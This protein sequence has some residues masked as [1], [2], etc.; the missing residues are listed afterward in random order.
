[1]EL[2]SGFAEVIKHALISD[3]ERWDSIIKNPL[4]GQ[5][6]DALINHSVNFK[7]RVTTEDPT[8]KGLR[9]ILN[10]GHT[11]GHAM[12]SFLLEAGRKVMHG[13]AVA[14][15]LIA[16]T[17]IG[18]QRHMINDESFAQLYQYVLSIFGKIVFHENEVEHIALL[19]RQDKKNKGNKILCVLP[20]GIGH[21]KWD[22]EISLDEVKAGLNFYRL[23]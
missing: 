14:A 3:Q 12:E 8:E 5:D 1:M 13:E 15:G 21:A 17:W 23:L 9:K 18:H 10:A 2:R 7:A 16:E 4:D 20:D 19:A 6:W 11:L 22:C